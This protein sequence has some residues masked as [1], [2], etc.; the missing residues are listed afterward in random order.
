MPS[1]KKLQYEFCCGVKIWLLPQGQQLPAEKFMWAKIQLFALP[2]LPVLARDTVLTRNL[3]WRSFT[4]AGPLENM[5]SRANYC[6]HKKK[7]LFFFFAR[8]QE[9]FQSESANHQFKL[10]NQWVVAVAKAKSMLKIWPMDRFGPLS[11]TPHLPSFPHP[12]S[13]RAAIEELIRHKGKYEWIG[14]SERRKSRRKDLL[15]VSE[16]L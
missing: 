8:F 3:N 13:P 1:P 11:H 16:Q 14:L 7:L 9:L 2:S 4:F 6:T 15:F 12:L 5:I 10:K